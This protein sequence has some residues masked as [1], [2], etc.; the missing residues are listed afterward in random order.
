MT[1]V[2]RGNKKLTNLCY[3]LFLL[4]L[5]GVI[6]AK[7][8]SRVLENRE[9]KIII[10]DVI[11][12]SHPLMP[13]FPYAVNFSQH[14]R[15]YETSKA[16]IWSHLWPQYRTITLKWRTGRVHYAWID[17]GQTQRKS[18]CVAPLGQLNHLYGAFPLLLLFFF[19][20]D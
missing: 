9:R 8:F 4:N 5:Q 14:Q 15:L 17:M 3:F 20:F 13:S 7:Y 16:R 18:P 11:Q 2:R 12:S 6:K 10:T 1:Y 19:F